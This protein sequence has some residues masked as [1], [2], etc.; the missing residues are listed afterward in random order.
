M[1]LDAPR[2]GP[3]LRQLLA[4]QKL[5]ATLCLF[6]ALGF[7]LAGSLRVHKVYEPGHEAFGLVTVH[8]VSDFQLVVD[9]TCGGVRKQGDRLYSTYDR[10]ETRGRRSCPT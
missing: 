8:S 3:V 10:S 6:V 1:T 7:L 4:H 5:L 2:P 9:A